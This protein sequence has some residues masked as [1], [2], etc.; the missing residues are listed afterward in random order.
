MLK[1][2]IYETLN[3]EELINITNKL[4]LF[5]RILKQTRFIKSLFTEEQFINQYMNNLSIKNE[6]VDFKYEDFKHKISE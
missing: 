6:L 4:E 3:K 1:K 5:R 2:S